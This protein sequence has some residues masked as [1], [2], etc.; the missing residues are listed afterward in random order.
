MISYADVEKLREMYAHGSAVLSLY[1]PVP[2][3]PAGV[4]SLAARAGDLMAG[5]S[6]VSLDGLRTAGVRRPDRDAVRGALAAHG[7]DRLGHTVA[8]FAYEELGLFEAVRLPCVLLERAVLATRPHIRPLPA[9]LQRCP[10]Y[11]V[12]IADRRHAWVLAPRWAAREAKQRGAKLT[13]CHAWAPDYLA[14]LSEAPVFDLAQCRGEEI[15]SLGLHYAEITVGSSGV[16]PLL[17]RGS[18]ACVLCEHSRTADIVVDSR[19]R[20]YRGGEA[21]GA[22]HRRTPEAALR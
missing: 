7:R 9:A 13:V 15:L 11:R 1:L 14:L 19:G 21:A 18:D 12:A 8:F 5:V 20:A 16:W 3:D 4:R 17:M 2:L 22:H 6:A 10:D